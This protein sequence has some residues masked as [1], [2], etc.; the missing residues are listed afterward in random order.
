MDY[1]IYVDNA[2]KFVS[3]VINCLK[4]G[5]DLSGNKIETWTYDS[6]KP[7]EIIIVHIPN[8][9]REKAYIRLIC[10]SCNTKVRVKFCY[11]DSYAKIEAADEGYLLGRF[12]ELLLAHFDSDFRTVEFSKSLIRR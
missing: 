9:W 12:T 7:N 4:K 5:E 1:V 8:Q 3:K 11:R 2:H 6:V 10:S